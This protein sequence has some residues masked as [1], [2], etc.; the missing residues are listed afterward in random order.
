MYVDGKTV[1]TIISCNS[2]QE[3]G[4]FRNLGLVSILVLEGWFQ[5]VVT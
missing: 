5:G 4:H 1:L 3:F 2:I